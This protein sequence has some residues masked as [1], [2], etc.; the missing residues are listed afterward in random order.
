MRFAVLAFAESLPALTVASVATGFA[1]A[2]FNPAVRAYVA[3]EAADRRLDAFALF[4][5]LYQAGILVGPLV[6]LALTGVAFRLTATVAALIFAVL[7]VLQMAALPAGRGGHDRPV[8]SVGQAWGTVLR[9]RDFLLFA[10]VM[11]G[12]YVLT[13]QIYLVLPLAMRRH[14]SSD[15]GADGRGGRHLRR[16]RTCHGGGS[17][18]HYGLVPAALGRSAII[19]GRVLADGIG[20]PVAGLR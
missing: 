20:V 9:N 4:N 6:G 16:V 11:A 12:S 2:L 3:L 14:I 7:A 13:F 17:A 19:D 10:A 8:G 18:S 5:V 15:T 1:G